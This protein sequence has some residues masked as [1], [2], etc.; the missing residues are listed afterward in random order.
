MSEVFVDSWVLRL[1]FDIF[2]LQD[3]TPFVLG[4]AQRRP[5]V[6][7]MTILAVIFFFWVRIKHTGGISTF[8]YFGS[9]FFWV[10]FF[11]A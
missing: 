6:S 11:W 1:D 7:R 10:I 4:E 9:D 3:P 5:K 2:L 8:I